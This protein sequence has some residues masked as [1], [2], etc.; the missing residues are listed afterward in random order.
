[1]A[2]K[3]QIVLND[4]NLFCEVLKSAVK[5]VDSAK[6]NISST[7]LEIY[8]ARNRIARCEIT[9]NCVTSENPIEF[10]LENL[11]MFNKIL[12]TVKEIHDND[13]SEL[14]FLF[15]HPFLRFESKKFKTKYSTCL[16]TVIDKW[17][18]KKVETT[19]T[20]MFEFTTTSDLIKRINSHSFLFEASKTV[21]VYIETKDDMEANSVFATLGNAETNLNNEITTKLGLVTSG[22]LNGRRLILDL[23]RLNLFNAIQAPEISIALMNLNILVSK[24]RILGKSGSYF[25]LTIYNTFLKS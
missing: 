14:K 7:G 24:S 22:T 19:L 11:S 21:R 2:T 3:Q 4:F 5:I 12:N 6:I 8:G 20:P 1:M 15:D 10:C 25:D 23:E 9:S 18:S 13:Y 16:E 17:V